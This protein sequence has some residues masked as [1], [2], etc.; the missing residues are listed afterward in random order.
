LKEFKGGHEE[1]YIP[2]P[3]T[4]SDIGPAFAPSRAVDCRMVIR[5]KL[6]IPQVLIQ[7]GDE[8]SAEIKWEDFQEIKDG[9]PAFNLEDKVELKGG[10]IVMKGKM[11][12]DNV[13]GD[14]AKIAPTN[15]EELRRG[16]R[17]RVA[18]TRLGGYI[19]SM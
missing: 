16:S 3:L 8:P 6:H 7:W 1:P 4:T 14:S 11:G 12:I 10:C 17:K 5:G 9:Y 15:L 18:S 19:T 2:L 13:S